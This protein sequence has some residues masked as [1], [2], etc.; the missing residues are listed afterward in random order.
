MLDNE[1][2]IKYGPT[3]IILSCI[4]WSVMV[5]YLQYIL[6]TEENDE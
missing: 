5:Q 1:P 6:Y 4:I 3:I 2:L